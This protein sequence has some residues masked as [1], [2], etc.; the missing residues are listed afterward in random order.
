MGRRNGCAAD[1]H[2]GGAAVVGDRQPLEV[3]RERVVGRGSRGPRCARGGW[4]CRSRCSRRCASARACSTSACGTRQARTALRARAAGAGLRAASNSAWRSARQAAGPRARKSLSASPAQARSGLRR[5]ARHRAGARQARRGRS[6]GRRWPR[7]RERPRCCRRGGTR[8][9]A[10]SG[11]GSR[12]LRRWPIRAS[13]ARAGSWVWL[14]QRRR[15]HGVQAV[16]ISASSKIATARVQ[17]AEAPR[18]LC[19]KQ[20]MKKPSA[21]SAS[22]LCSFSMWQ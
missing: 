9:T 7:R 16:A 2:A 17:P 6:P 8:R 20:L 5:R 15:C 1:H 4:R 3:G 22:R 10:G 21:G 12:C 18:I 19:G 13:C 11:S 14:S